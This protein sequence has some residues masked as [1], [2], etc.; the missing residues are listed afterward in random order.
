MSAL[1]HE[2]TSSAL[3]IYVRF[4]GQSGHWMSAFGVRSVL[5]SDVRFA[6]PADGLT[7]PSREG[8]IKTPFKD[9][10][11]EPRETAVLNRP[12]YV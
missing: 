6:P 3:A 10:D 9:R 4:W 5:A 8:C 1:G 12:T 7:D 11:L 2:R